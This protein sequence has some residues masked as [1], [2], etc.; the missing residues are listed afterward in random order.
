MDRD[1]LPHLI[2]KHHP[3][4]KW[5]QG[6]P[7]KVFSNV[8]GTKQVMKPKPHKLYKDDLAAHLR[9][10]INIYLHFSSNVGKFTL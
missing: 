8:H 9:Q 10:V 5:S 7:P 1:R 4:R 2:K 6:W 3:C